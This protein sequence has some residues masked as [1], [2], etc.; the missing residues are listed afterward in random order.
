MWRKDL[1][2]S[3]SQKQIMVSWIIPKNER[4][5]N[6]QY[7]KLLQRSFF[8][9]IQ[10]NIFF[11]RFSDLYYGS[12]KSETVKSHL[13]AVCWRRKVF[14]L[15]EIGPNRV[16]WTIAQCSV[17]YKRIPRLLGFCP[18]ILCKKWGFFCFNLKTFLL[19]HFFLG[20]NLSSRLWPALPQL[21]GRSKK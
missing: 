11:S 5:G 15:K 18:L 13:C 19:K 4:W 6:F 12:N 9:R 14:K 17:L 10:D 20:T 2:V 8:G 21:Q 7:I 3:K 16:I 1:K